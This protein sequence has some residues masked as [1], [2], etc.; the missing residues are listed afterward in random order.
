MPDPLTQSKSK[1]VF[2]LDGMA[3]AYRS[4]FAFIRSPLTNA[5]GILTS[6]VYG[7]LMA[8][9]RIINQEQPDEIVVVFDA[10]GDTFRHEMFPDY[11]ATREKMPEEMIPQ[12]AWIRRAIEGLGIPFI[13][14]ERRRRYAREEGSRGGQGRVDRVRRQGHDAARHREGASLQHHEAGPER[15][16]ARRTG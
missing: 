13:S 14:I 3:L 6:A 7:F 2:L 8:V 9:D 16:R 4:H 15:R 11:K 10:P 1:R 12:L 5:Q